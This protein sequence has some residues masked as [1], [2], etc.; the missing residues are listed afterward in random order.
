MRDDKPLFLVAL[1]LACLAVL[2]VLLLAVIHT[3]FG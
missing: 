3:G 1:L 2:V